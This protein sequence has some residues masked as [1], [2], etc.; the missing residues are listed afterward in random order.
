MSSFSQSCLD[1]QQWSLN[2]EVYAAS[3]CLIA[4]NV[5]VHKLSKPNVE[6]S[7]SAS[8]IFELTKIFCESAA[9]S[10]ELVTVDFPAGVFY[11]FKFL[12]DRVSTCTFGK[13]LFLV[14]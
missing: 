14:S 1:E 10:W 13:Y 5:E 7:P 12:L 6:D 11:I 4:L 3:Y 8:V 9:K 2:D